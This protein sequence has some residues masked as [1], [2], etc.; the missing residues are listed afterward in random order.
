L[1][2]SVSVPLSLNQDSIEDETINLPLTPIK[3]IEVQTDDLPNDGPSSPRFCDGEKRFDDD[4]DTQ[5]LPGWLRVLSLSL[6]LQRKYD[7]DPRSLLL[8]VIVL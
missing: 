5:Q 7:S 3:H 8:I 1:H 2:R 6:E 4:E